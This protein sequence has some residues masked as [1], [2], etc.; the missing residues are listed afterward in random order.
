MS[1]FSP[2]LQDSTDEQL[3]LLDKKRLVRKIGMISEEE[4]KTVKNELKR[5]L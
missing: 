3:R 1:N 4:F 5:L 2:K